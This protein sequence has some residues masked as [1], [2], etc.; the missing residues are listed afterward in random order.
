M[1]ETM[2]KARKLNRTRLKY[3]VMVHPANLL[4]LGLVVICRA[5]FPV[6]AW[7]YLIASSPNPVGSGARAL[8]MGGAFIAVAD[9]ATASSWNPAGLVQL[10][11]PE[12]S[13]VTVYNNR[14]ENIRYESLPESG[15]NQTVS[16]LDINYLSAA[17]PFVLFNRN[18]LVSINYQNLY[19]FKREI[20][21]DRAYGSSPRNE[22]K[23][24]FD[25]DRDGSLKTISPAFAS[26]I[27]KNLSLGITLNFWDDDLGNNKWVTE[28]HTY[29]SGTFG[30]THF[31]SD[32]E[33]KDTY[34]LSGVNF[35]L[36]LLWR[37]NGMFS[38]GTVFKAPFT[39][40]LKHNRSSTFSEYD[41]LLFGPDKTTVQTQNNSFYETLDM[42][43]SYGAGLAV[44]LNDALTLALDAY[45]T[46]WDDFVLHN[47]DG[48]NISLVTGKSTS[49]SDVSDTTQVRLGGE[50]L[51]IREK[52]VIPVRAGIFYDPE[53]AEGDPDDFW[54]VSLGTGI[55]YR[56]IVYDL[57]YQYRFGKD[58]RT[59]VNGAGASSQDVFQH[60]V[61]MSI[62]YHF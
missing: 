50:Y 4:L 48:Q 42:P 36:G 58:V 46:K 15:G 38:V 18:M 41:D 21:L 47:V 45:H 52:S 49:E 7:S 19:N 33:V 1:D 57:A 5:L 22:M 60:S 27:F 56:N 26:Q 24:S 32:L 62:I 53:P 9:D 37:L 44:R 2:I 17:Y 16:T 20:E 55:G 40:D 35:N 61:Y 43:M 8:G 30:L 14:T 28:T 39:A 34:W 54:G 23:E 29:D 3:R 12:I 51:I 13:I 25:Y 10:E 6:S 31:H 11:T 59:G